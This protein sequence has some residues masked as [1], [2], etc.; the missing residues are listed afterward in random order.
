MIEA[1]KQAFIQHFGKE[2]IMVKSPGRVNL[3]G[4]H[5]D[6]NNGFV[7]P[8]AVNAA[9]YFACK[10]NNEN[11]Y[12]FYS[13]D[14]NDS[15]ETSV[16]QI[17]KCDKDWANY[18][19]GVIAQFVKA[20]KYI[21][22]FD[23]VFG[24]DVPIGAGMSS[25]AAIET[26]LAFAINHM[27]TF[28]YETIDLVKFSQKAE[29]E[30]AGVQC[31]IMDQFA[32]MHGKDSHVIKLDCRSLA[33]ELY[34]LDMNDQL[35]I[36]VNTGVKHSLASSEYN[37]RRQECEAGV[38]LLQKYQPNIHALRDVSLDLLNAHKNEMDAEVYD[39]CSYVIEENMR[40]ELACKA[41]ENN[42][43]T[44]F[45][46]QMYGSHEGLKIKYQVSCP[47]LDQLVDLSKTID[48][49]M[50]ARMMGGGFGGCTINLV[51]KEAAANFEKAVLATY[52]TPEGKSPQI[53][54]VSIED[55]TH[56]IHY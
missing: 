3:I 23:C 16:N 1:I 36:L 15:Y 40:L 5:T 14:L 39:R 53:I 11:K 27:Q 51:K 20:G 12:R 42:D 46:A 56:L 43:F 33:Y 55:G 17:D 13:Y 22:G 9:I 31:G 44:T 38:A 49:V 28:N 48:G 35:I 26:G 25:S 37:K 18:L 24:G 29:H 4:E 34:P 45:G 41:L 52:K 19:L 54:K 2:P 8:A 10:S 47:E 32:A 7:L 6:Y 50:G 30:Y 21:G